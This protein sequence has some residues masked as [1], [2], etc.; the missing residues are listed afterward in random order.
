M[1]FTRSLAAASLIALSLTAFGAQAQQPGNPPPAPQARQTLAPLTPDQ[2]KT[3]IEGRLALQRSDLKVGKVIEK[4]AQ[5][6]DVELLKADGTVQE[7]ALV[8]KTFARSAGALDRHGHHGRPGPGGM[9]MK[10]CG[11]GL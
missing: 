10:D 4:D 8:D 7:H 2:V 5:T 1:N 3:V 9:G 11:K 6:Y